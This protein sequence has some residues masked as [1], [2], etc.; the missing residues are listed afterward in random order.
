MS[1]QSDDLPPAL[2][3][4]SE[5][6]RRPGAVEDGALSRALAAGLTGRR[7]RSSGARSRARGERKPP[8]GTSRSRA[9]RRVVSF[10]AP[11][12]ES[13]GR[14]P[15]QPFA[16]DRSSRS[17]ASSLRDPPLGRRRARSSGPP[18]PDP[19]LSR[20]PF[21]R[22]SPSIVG[23]LGARE[24]SAIPERRVRPTPII[25]RRRRRSYS[26]GERSTTENRTPYCHSPVSKSFRAKGPTLTPKYSAQW[27]P[28]PNSFRFPTS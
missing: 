5:R 9:E 8:R 13:A 1:P 2:R 28:T 11:L 23:D 7:R 4:P 24:N 17:P 26:I 6:P 12:C 21:P 15:S 19:E 3:G 25:L 10:R 20:R 22:T 14:I 27:T 16:G 18:D